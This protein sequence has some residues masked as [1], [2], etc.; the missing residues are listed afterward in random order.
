MI[1]GASGGWVK[2]GLW[3]TLVS[4]TVTGQL[5]A[6]ERPA[7]PPPP[8]P[9]APTTPAA[10]VPAIP[11]AA[12]APAVTPVASAPAPAVSR[13]SFRLFNRRKDRPRR[14]PLRRFRARIRALF[15]RGN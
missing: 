2:A 6:Q 11:A 5:Q 9:V 12:P 10:P 7:I 13:T 4:L 1:Q 8:T 14:R 3:L 15:H